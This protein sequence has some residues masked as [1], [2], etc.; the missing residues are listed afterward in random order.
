MATSARSA[1]SRPPRS[2]PRSADSTS[3]STIAGAV[4]SRSCTALPTASAAGPR[5]SNST[6]ALASMTLNTAEQL[7]FP[8]VPVGAHPVGDRAGTQIHRL[9]RRQFLQPATWRRLDLAAKQARHVL[10]ERNPFMSSTPTQLSMQ[11]LRK[12]AYLQRG[13]TG[14]LACTVHAR[15]RSNST[16]LPTANSHGASTGVQPSLLY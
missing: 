15:L 6:T 11:L 9:V 13:H 7:L 2:S 14:S 10:T 4:S 16:A 3:A 8:S 1:L 5:S 12:V